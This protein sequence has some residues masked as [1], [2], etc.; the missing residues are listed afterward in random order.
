MKRGDFKDIY[1]WAKW[2]ANYGEDKFYEQCS[3]RNIDCHRALKSLRYD[4]VIEIN[5]KLKK[6]Q[7]KSVSLGDTS[8]KN[9]YRVPLSS[10]KVTTGERIIYKKDEVDYFVFY[11]YE[12]DEIYLV[13]AEILLNTKKDRIRVYD[14]DFTTP[15]NDSKALDLKKYKNW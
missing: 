4:F 15:K 12:H 2:L 3:R 10:K 13:P 5:G 11:L 6:V 14:S 7:V 1:D 9:T 8:S